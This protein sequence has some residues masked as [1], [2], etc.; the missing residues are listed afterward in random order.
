MSTPSGFNRMASP[1]GTDVPVAAISRWKD[2]TLKNLD[3]TFAFKHWSLRQRFSLAL[4]T[5]VMVIAVSTYGTRLLGKA[6]TFHFLERNHM[7]LALRA[8][9]ALSRIEQAAQN[10]SETRIEDIGGMLNEMRD[11]AVRAGEETFGI[12]K[13]LLSLLGFSP[14]IELPA[15]DIGDVDA[16]LATIASGSAAKGPM[17]LELA[18]RLR[19]GMDAVMQNSREF[20]PLTSAASRFIKV[21]VAV[22]SLLC[23]LALIWTVTGLRR[24]TLRPL[25]TAVVSAQRVAGGDLTENLSAVGHDEAAQLTQAL[26]DMNASLGRLVRA[27]RED[28]DQIAESAATVRQQSE[29]GAIGMQQQ[30][31]AVTQISST[32]EELAVSIAVVADRAG[33]VKLLSAES[34]A[35]SRMGWEHMQHLAGNVGEIRQAV[36]EIRQ[37][38]EAFMRNT[39]SISALTQQVKAIAEQTNL[40]AL[41][42]AIEAARAGESGRGFAVVADEVR[43]LAEQSRRSGED[44]ENL[45]RLLSENSQSVARSVERG[46]ETLHSGQAYMSNTMEALETAIGRVEEANRGIDEIGLSVKEQAVAGNDI[47]RNMENISSAL[48]ATSAGL[49]VSLQT[50][51]GLDQLAERLQAAV[52]SFRV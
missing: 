31:D 8:D 28:A 39:G 3:E 4:F 40:L 14:L 13:T 41:N 19:P 34:L 26:A 33:E 25:E 32:V 11:L 1:I 9:A 36:E 5:T 2:M 12:E 48:E 44:I 37:T 50:A 10:A 42:A 51:R 49:A 17:N 24:R 21:N 43:K 7:E 18:V 46:V 47:A 22:L 35:S 23:A 29:A 38:T 15:K 30:S 16:M 20:A 45:T 52:G 6:A 27:A